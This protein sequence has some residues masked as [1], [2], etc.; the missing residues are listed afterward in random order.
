MRAFLSHLVPTFTSQKLSTGIDDVSLDP[1]VDQ[2]AHSPLGDGYWQSI[3]RGHNTFSSVSQALIV[4]QGMVKQ[5]EERGSSVSWLAESSAVVCF[6]AVTLGYQNA[7][8]PDHF[9]HC[10]A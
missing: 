10:L 7:L 2:W 9:I 3:I 6:G 4:I 5:E 8:C 1:L